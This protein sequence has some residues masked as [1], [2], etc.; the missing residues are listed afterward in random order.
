LRA[1]LSGRF[2]K[3]GA[4]AGAFDDLP[5]NRLDRLMQTPAGLGPA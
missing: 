2:R 5:V 4:V 1:C 3:D